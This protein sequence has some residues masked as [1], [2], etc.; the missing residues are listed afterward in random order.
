MKT[1]SPNKVLISKLLREKSSMLIK[2]KPIKITNLPLDWNSTIQSSE[3]LRNLNK[4]NKKLGNLLK[5]LKRKRPN[6]KISNFSLNKRSKIKPNKKSIKI[7]LMKKNL[8]SLKRKRFL[9][10]IIKMKF[11]R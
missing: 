9:K 4:R 7:L 8:S 5:K 6:L 10:E 1:K 11:K 2:T 3:T